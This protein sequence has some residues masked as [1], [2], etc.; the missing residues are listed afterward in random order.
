[1]NIMF[2]DRIGLGCLRKLIS[3]GVDPQIGMLMAEPHYSGQPQQA[4]L[5][6]F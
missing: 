4:P 6:P 3:I 5:M 2:S 1:M